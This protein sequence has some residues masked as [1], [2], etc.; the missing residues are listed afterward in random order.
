MPA[1][2]QRLREIAA[3]AL[4]AFGMISTLFNTITLLFG[5]D[6]CVA[7]GIG[8]M[9]RTGSQGT[10]IPFAYRALGATG[11]LLNPVVIAAPVGAAA[12]VH[13]QVRLRSSKGIALVSLLTVVLAGVFGLVALFASFGAENATGYMKTT[14]FCIGLTEL[15]VTAVAA[16][17]ILGYFKQHG[18]ARVAAPYGLQP[19]PGP[20]N[21]PQQQQ[22][23]QQPPGGGPAWG[24]G[25]GPGSGPAWG[26]SQPQWGPP[27]QQG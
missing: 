3:F 12:L 1:T 22:Q 17:L 25:G 8:A 11:S 16:W 10:T 23:W 5:P 7:T 27:Q 24:P 6:G 13:V 2:A 18:P 14:S 20:W 9:T 21:Q 19:P 4:L 26:P 15:G